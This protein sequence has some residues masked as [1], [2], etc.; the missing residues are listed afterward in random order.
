MY[1]LIRLCSP[2]FSH[3]EDAVENTS[4]FVMIAAKSNDSC[5]ARHIR[6]LGGF[7]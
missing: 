3:Q 5:D 4:T 7:K 6:L 1:K 2:R